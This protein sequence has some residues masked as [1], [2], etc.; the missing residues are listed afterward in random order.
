MTGWSI[1]R[2]SIT[3]RFIAMML[4]FLSLLIAGAGIV[5]YLNHSALTEYQTALQTTTQKQDLV[6]E[7]SEH[8]SQ[9]FFRARGYYAFLNPNEYNELFI[10]KEKLEQALESLKKLPLN[11]EEQVRVASIESF[12]TNFFTNVFPTASNY[13]KTGDYESLRKFSSSGLTQ[14]V[15]NL[16]QYAVRYE[17]EHE[18]VLYKKN[19]A[20]FQKLSQQSTWFLVYALMVLV[21]MVVVTI[22]TTRDIGRPL[23]RLSKDAEQFANGG[24]PLLQDLNRVDEIG[25]L[26]RSLNYLIRQIQAKE[27]VLMAQ[28]E[29][30]QAQQ[31]ELMMQQEELQ[32]A[33]GKMEENER[34]LEKK[35]RFILSLANT[36]DKT[37]LLSSIIRNISEVTDADK[38]VIV[39]LNTDRDAASFGVSQNVL[40]QLRKGLDEGPFVRIKETSQPYVLIRESTD[41]ERGYTEELSRTSELYLP[42]LDANLTIVACIILSRID[43]KFTDLELQVIIGL[44]KQISLALDKLA[45]FE[46]TERQRKMTQD[47][48][49]SV[50]EGIQLIDLDGET[51]QVNRNFCELLSYDNQLASQGFDL[52]QFL[53]YLQSQTSEPDRLIQYVRAVVLNEG[54]IPSGSI[55]FQMTGPQVRYIQL[56]AEP[57]Y[58]NQ[59]KWSTL[60]VYRDFTNEYEI[61]QMKSEF[62]STVSH[63]LR[64]PL[65]SV[66][67]FAELLLT[68]ELK[69]E[70]QQRYI[71]T[72][73]QE[74]NRLTALINDFLD[75]QRMESG[76]QTY[77]VENV[78]IDRV[79]RDIF[80][81]YRVQSPLHRFELDLQTEQT[82]V[83]G[84]QTKLRQVFVNLISNAVK[85]S[86]HGG[87][88]RVRCQQDG[89]RLLVVVQDEGLG[90]PAEAIPHLF[91]KFY[92]VDNS[93]RR[94]IGGTGLGLAIVREI[95]HMHQ[96]EVTVTSE[97]GKGSTFTVTLPLAE[98]AL[99]AGYLS[100]TEEAVSPTGQCN[101]N[102]V[103]IE[104]DLNLTELLRDELTS[105]GFRVN[106]FS[107]APEAVAAIEELRPDAVVL[108]LILKD[109]E[110]GWMVI[111]EIR[112][113]PDLRTI[114]IVISSAIEE[115]KKA[116]DLGATGYLIKPYHPDTLS[117][118][119]L[120]AIANHEATGQIF[121]P[122]KQ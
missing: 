119:I 45:M 51:L 57:L 13:A 100:G 40:E 41:A 60:L 120:L 103:I 53:S 4:L 25:R 113:N 95:V 121:I 54:A 61:D 110:S 68:K 27:E 94:E 72:I 34:Y 99:S 109:G 20:L 30:L 2:K 35:N 11:Q 32:E 26:S 86:P 102:V 90:I 39:M 85:Y 66:L 8:T 63:E 33:L 12:F 114:P 10:E 6:R 28:N 81:L 3:R 44:A 56:Y 98:H 50:Q 105:S 89:N 1:I 83:Y 17:D 38:G 22:Q 91:T 78:A 18:Q 97:S 48:L 59:E 29:E 82:T 7:I 118:A 115:K 69:P 79:I 104:D 112:K 71:A 37:E 67:G 117:K 101:G 42:V 93:D 87:L 55:V 24:T 16:L 88:V 52:E 5:Q 49:D 65:A 23:V 75:L 77:E 76:R 47:M 70:R 96:G 84:D 58:R 15:N 31:D 111:E 9:I 106:S 107:T 74:A 92:R 108:D 80:G 64:T 43:R 14:A 46:E 21:I 19:Q 73:Y 116:F 122:D 62:V 36:L